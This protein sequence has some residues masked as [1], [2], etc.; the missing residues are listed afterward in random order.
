[1][2][3]KRVLVLIQ[4]GV[5]SLHRRQAHEQNLHNETKTK[6]SSLGQ[7]TNAEWKRGRVVNQ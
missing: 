1:M 7:T 6:Q 4:V 2:A 3:F 5:A